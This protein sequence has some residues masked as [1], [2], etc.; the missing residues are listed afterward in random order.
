MATIRIT[1]LSQT[2]SSTP[3]DNTRVDIKKKIEDNISSRLSSSGSSDSF[4]NMDFGKLMMLS[5]LMNKGGSGGFDMSSLMSLMMMKRLCPEMFGGTPK[6]TG[7]ASGDS[8]T[9]S[10]SGSSASSSTTTETKTDGMK[11]NKYTVAKDGETLHDLVKR[12]LDIKTEDAKL[13]A[14]EKAKIKAEEE[15]LCELNP[16]DIKGKIKGD[17]TLDNLKVE[18]DASLL[19]KKTAPAAKPKDGNPSA[20]NPTVVKPSEEKLLEGGF[21]KMGNDNSFKVGQNDPTLPRFT[22]EKDKNGNELSKLI[23]DMKNN[24]YIYNNNDTKNPD[25]NIKNSKGMIKKNDAGEFFIEYETNALESRGQA[26]RK[27]YD[28]EGKPLREEIIARPTTGI[29]LHDGHNLSVYRT[30]DKFQEEHNDRDGKIFTGKN[31]ANQNVKYS[32]NGVN[33]SWFSKKWTVIDGDKSYTCETQSIAGG[34]YPKYFSY[35]DENSKKEVRIFLDKDF[36][37]VL[38]KELTSQDGEVI[39]TTELSNVDEQRAEIESKIRNQRPS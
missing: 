25:V 16:N 20:S 21:T 22:V 11:S 32:F 3:V 17:V 34:K 37:P 31:S 23:L 36:K 6:S 13:S 15:R 33:A 7:D 5:F 18:A 4:A 26:V 29:D 12:R 35:T 27:Y 38:R 24:K 39:K 10:S 30:D 8:S 14:D 28:S 9:S 19:L 1:G 2:S